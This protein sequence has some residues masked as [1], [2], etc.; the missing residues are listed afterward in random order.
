MGGT[1]E[2]RREHDGY[3]LTVVVLS[4]SLVCRG[5]LYP[6]RAPASRQGRNSLSAV[7][8]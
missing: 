7:R 1:Y 6:V 3:L 8:N 4:S 2:A 5:K